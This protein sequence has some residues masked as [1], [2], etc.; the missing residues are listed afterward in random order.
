MSLQSDPLNW[1]SHVNYVRDI[2]RGNPDGQWLI[3]SEGGTPLGH[4]NARRRSRDVWHWSFYKGAHPGPRG[5]G[6]R[7]VA[8][9]LRRIF[10]R[11]D[12][13]AITADVIARNGTSDRLHR[14]LGF[15]QTGRREDGNI[16]EFRLNRCDMRA[17]LGQSDGGASE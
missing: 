5:A 9:F 15:V 12:V 2:A 7:M 16:L 14:Q 1:D 8:A 4:V 13:A 3:Y 6:Q 10:E 17:R 11:P